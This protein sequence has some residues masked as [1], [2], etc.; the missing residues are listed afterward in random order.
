MSYQTDQKRPCTV[1]VV[2]SAEI[3]VQ[4]NAEE[5]VDT[6]AS[7]STTEQ[8]K[9][10]KQIYIITLCIGLIQ[11]VVALDATILVTALPVGYQVYLARSNLL[12]KSSDH[13]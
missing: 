2:S 12:T 5:K 7:V 4:S 9:P 8:W 3:S 13:C 6:H 11:F 10:T 1:T